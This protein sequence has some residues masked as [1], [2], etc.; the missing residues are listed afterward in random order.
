LYGYNRQ[1][2]LSIRH[3]ARVKRQTDRQTDRQ[4]DRQ[5][6]RQN[7]NPQDRAIIA[8]LRSKH[9]QNSENHHVVLNR[10]SP[11]SNFSLQKYTI[12]T[13]C[14]VQPSQ[15]HQ[16]KTA[17]KHRCITYILIRI[18]FTITSH[19]RISFPFLPFFVNSNNTGNV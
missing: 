6:D 3:E 5:M 13:D 16:I 4:I 9:C 17:V 7:Y 10:A 15:N 1:Y 2:V 11:V 19:F 8:A 18:S 12:A 14:I